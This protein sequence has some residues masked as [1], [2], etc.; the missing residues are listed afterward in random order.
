[1]KEGHWP[2]FWERWGWN[3]KLRSPSREIVRMAEGVENG[4]SL[5]SPRGGGGAAQ[6][7]IGHCF[8]NPL[9]G[10][11]NELSYSEKAKRL[12]KTSENFLET[13]FCACMC[14]WTSEIVPSGTLLRSEA[15]QLKDPHPRSDSML[16]LW[17]WSLR[18][19]RRTDGLW[20]LPPR[21]LQQ[22]L[23]RLCQRL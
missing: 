17:S 1:M 19:K 22:R 8:S 3:S 9:R 14:M 12:L 10:F 6:R 7:G 4:G 2:F 15:G 11:Q 18:R 5:V 21:L 13:P 20:P 16:S 23:F